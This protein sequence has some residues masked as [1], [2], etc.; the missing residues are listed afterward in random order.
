M[1]NLNSC[2]WYLL[3]ML[4][5]SIVCFHPDIEAFSSLFAKCWRFVLSFRPCYPKVW[6]PH[7]FSFYYW[8]QGLHCNG[9]CLY[10]FVLRCMH[11]LETLQ[12]TRKY[13]YVHWKISLM[14]QS[15]LLGGLWRPLMLSS[16]VD[17]LMWTPICLVV[18][19]RTVYV[20]HQLHHGFPSW[21]LFM[22][23]FCDIGPWGWSVNLQLS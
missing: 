18:T 1:K 21:K 9:R 2:L 11:L 10:H 6:M 12:S 15:I 23:H 3:M 5:P 22:M 7:Q 17:L 4:P 13:L 19:S 20:N 16:R 14:Q 8:L